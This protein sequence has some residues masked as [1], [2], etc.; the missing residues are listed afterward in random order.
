MSFAR[1]LSFKMNQALNE[2]PNCKKLTPTIFCS[3]ACANH[4]NRNAQRKKNVQYRSGFPIN[5]Q[6]ELDGLVHVMRPLFRKWQDKKGIRTAE[7]Q[8]LLLGAFKGMKFNFDEKSLAGYVTLERRK[9]TST[10]EAFRGGGIRVLVD[11][12][13][14][15]A[16][17]VEILAI[18]SRAKRICNGDDLKKGFVKDV[19]KS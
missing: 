2:C 12:H 14:T 9:S 7:F 3:R 17:G 16:I 19:V 4:F 13:R 15:R 5:I 8:A 18:D 6:P 11:F 1:S 10:K